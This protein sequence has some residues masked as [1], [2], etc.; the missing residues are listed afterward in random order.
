MYESEEARLAPGTLSNDQGELIIHHD[1]TITDDAAIIKSHINAATSTR[2]FQDAILDTIGTDFSASLHKRRQQ[3]YRA[4][5]MPSTDPSKELEVQVLPV[6][7]ET[8]VQ[9]LRRLVYEMTELEQELAQDAA[10]MHG[11]E[12]ATDAMI[13]HVSQVRQHLEQLGGTSLTMDKQSADM[14]QHLIQHLKALKLQ[15][16][17]KPTVDASSASTAQTETQNGV[18]YELYLNDQTA[19]LSHQQLSNTELVDRLSKLESALGISSTSI[20]DTSGANLTAPLIQTVSHLEHQLQI[21]TT[22]G[23]L[24][25]LTQKCTAL[26]Q[27]LDTY[28]STSKS[29]GTAPLD[30]VL[31][32]NLQKLTSQVLPLVPSLQPILDRLVALKT[33]HQEA[34]QT[35]TLLKQVVEEQTRVMSTLGHLEGVVSA[36][37]SSMAENQDRILDNLSALEKWNVGK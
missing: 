30:P 7:E 35:T 24:E 13:E 5:K 19:K 8:P 2:K 6:L 4:L 21:L 15:P 32:T 36:L 16:S 37:E 27:A 17:A 33:H 29:S 34:A 22:P 12:E 23:S 3:A 11:G 14:G 18:S 9:K 1:T 28:A 10:K 26:S 25:N 20:I 31:V